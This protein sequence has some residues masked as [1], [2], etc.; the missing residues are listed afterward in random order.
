MKAWLS[1]LRGTVFFFLCCRFL[2]TVCVKASSQDYQLGRWYLVFCFQVGNWAACGSSCWKWNNVCVSWYLVQFVFISMSAANN[3]C[4]LMFNF[5]LG[6]IFCCFLFFCR[7][8]FCG[9]ARCVVLFPTLIGTS[10]IFFIP[11]IR[12]YIGSGIGLIFFVSSQVRRF[13]S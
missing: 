4:P 5:I 8:G 3:R 13:W 1:T 7:S 6:V 9:S 11:V 12:E 2:L 10:K